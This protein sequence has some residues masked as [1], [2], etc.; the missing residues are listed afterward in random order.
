MRS[1]THAAPLTANAVRHIRHAA[2]HTAPHSPRHKARHATP[3][4]TPQVMPLAT[5]AP[6]PRFA[7]CNT[8]SKAVSYAKGYTTGRA[9]GQ[10][11]MHTA[12]HRI[13]THTARRTSSRVPKSLLPGGVPCRATAAFVLL[14][15]KTD[16]DT[17]TKH[18]CAHDVDAV[19]PPKCTAQAYGT[20]SVPYCPLHAR[21]IALR[22]QR[23]RSCV[24]TQPPPNVSWLSTG[25]TTCCSTRPAP[26]FQVFLCPAMLAPVA[27]HMPSGPD[28]PRNSHH[29]LVKRVFRPSC[30]PRALCTPVNATCII[31]VD[32]DQVRQEAACGSPA[33]MHICTPQSSFA[34][35]AAGLVQW[36]HDHPY[37][38]LRVSVAASG[39]AWVASGT[40]LKPTAD[41]TCTAARLGLGVRCGRSRDSGR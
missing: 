23:S 8:T 25:N 27:P 31:P 38:V 35:R 3:Q 36:L 10:T 20:N 26:A 7:K 41:V 2:R 28:A 17:H 9:A 18:A 1:P 30:A 37:T 34:P 24:L 16:F 21:D 29:H 15:S 5:P 6:V 12:P 13:A 40:E 39:R 22:C 19:P 14:L 32:N 33:C 11:T 4:A